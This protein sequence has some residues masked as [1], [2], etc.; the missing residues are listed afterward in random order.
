MQYKKDRKTEWQNGR[1]TVEQPPLS[2]HKRSLSRVDAPTSGLEL[3]SKK[4]SY[5]FSEG[6]K[7]GLKEK[8]TI[9]AKA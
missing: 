1:M 3:L 5:V 8:N 6:D 9:F 4:Q 7:D 2:D